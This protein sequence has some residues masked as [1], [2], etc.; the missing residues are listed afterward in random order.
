[1]ETSLHTLPNISE[2]AAAPA[3][4][5]AR[6]ASPPSARRTEFSSAPSQA[7]GGAGCFASAARPATD[8]IRRY[9]GWTMERDF[10][11]DSSGF[12]RSLREAVH[13]SGRRTLLDVT[14]FEPFTQASFSKLVD[15]DFP[16]RAAIGSRA[17]LTGRDIDR[18][19]AERV[20]PAA[21]R[22]IAIVQHALGTWHA[23]AFV[24]CSLLALAG[25]LGVTP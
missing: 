2:I 12:D 25:Y 22:A 20:G 21:S 24:T 14:D 18:L 23:G 15:M 10:V 13:V 7:E 8:D 1:M 3:A 11:V 9:R 6:P 5:T 19:H 17:P 16:T 4:G